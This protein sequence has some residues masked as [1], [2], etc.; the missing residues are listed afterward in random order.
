MVFVITKEHIIE[1]FRALGM[2]RYNLTEVEVEIFVVSFLCSRM[3]E[4]DPEV[5]FRYPIEWFRCGGSARWNG[6]GRVCHYNRG[7]G[8]NLGHAVQRSGTGQ[9]V[10]VV[11]GERMAA[12]ATVNR[13]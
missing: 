4:F 10:G 7:R 5:T 1:L 2:L 3:T 6:Q 13:T 12:N 8:V 11:K 9:V